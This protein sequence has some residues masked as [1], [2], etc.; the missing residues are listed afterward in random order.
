MGIILIFM[1]LSLIYIPLRFLFWISSVFWHDF[2]FAKVPTVSNYR[3]QRK[4][5]PEGW[6]ETP[7][8]WPIKKD[9]NQTEEKQKEMV[10]TP[11]SKQTEAGSERVDSVLRGQEEGGI[12]TA[13]DVGTSPGLR[14][15]FTKE[16]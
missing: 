7:E 14:S 2:I 10:S 9:F 6:T 3:D 15:A 1:I 8:T 12:S 11:P 5:S 16:E 4:I 13:R